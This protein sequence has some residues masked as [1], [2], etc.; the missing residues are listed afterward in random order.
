MYDMIKPSK[1]FLDSWSFDLITENSIYVD[2]L[3]D[4]EQYTGYQG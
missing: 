3:K 4:K 2:L 1:L